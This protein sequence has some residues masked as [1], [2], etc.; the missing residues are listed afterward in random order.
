MILFYTSKH[1]INGY[2]YKNNSFLKEERRKKIINY[3]NIFIPLIILN[4]I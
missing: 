1:T 2:F 4:F 3:T